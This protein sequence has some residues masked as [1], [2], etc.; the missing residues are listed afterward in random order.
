MSNYI[1][2]CIILFFCIAF[3]LILIYIIYLLIKFELEYI[4]SQRIIRNINRIIN[5]LNLNQPDIKEIQEH[6]KLQKKIND[7]IKSKYVIIINPNKEIEIG[8]NH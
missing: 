7:Q 5:Q 8:N 6:Y 3:L 4:R 2:Y 1:F